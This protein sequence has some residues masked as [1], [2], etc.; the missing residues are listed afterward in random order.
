[1]LPGNRAGRRLREILAWRAQNRA[2]PVLLQQPRILTP[3]GIAD[4]LCSTAPADGLLS[5]M[6]LVRVLRENQ[7]LDALFP[8]P[9]DG[10]DLPGWMRLAGEIEGLFDELDG[11]VVTCADGS[12]CGR[13]GQKAPYQ[14]LRMATRCGRPRLFMRATRRES[15]TCGA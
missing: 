15:P 2:H 4:L 7:A 3:H 14:S 13:R 6:V 8:H 10:D 11:E 1:M 9:P 5:V 12:V